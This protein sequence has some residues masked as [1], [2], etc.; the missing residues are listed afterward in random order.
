MVVKKIVLPEIGEGVM[1]AEIMKWY[2]KEGDHVKKFQNLVQVLADKGSLD[3]PSP[4]EGVVTKILVNE[5]ELVRVGTPI[6]EIETKDNREVMVQETTERTTEEKE[7][8]Q[9]AEKEIIEKSFKERPK[10][11]PAVRKLAAQLGISL[12]EIKGTGPGG[13]IT[14]DDVLEFKKR[15]EI[16]ESKPAEKAEILS[17]I[18][19]G[20]PKPKLK[21]KEER[22]K[23]KGIRRFIAERMLRAWLRIPHSS[24]TEIVIADRLIE[25]RERLKKHAETQGI[26]LT[27]MPFIMKAVVKALKEYPLLNGLYDPEWD[28]II[29]KKYYNIG[30]AVDTPQGLVVPVIKNVDE[31]SIFQLAKELRELAE[32]AREG[33]L[34]V[35]DVTDGTFSITNIG[36]IGS[37]VFSPIINYPEIAILGVSKIRKIYTEEGITNQMLVS[38]TF[39]HMVVDGAYAVRF[40]LKIK[41]LLEEPMLLL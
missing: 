36:S 18:P 11:S 16:E 4:Y 20:I 37:Y 26:K 13:I 28:E 29:I 7:T 12:E 5:G 8:S 40:L 39:N 17:W 38:I 19:D 10:A 9:K 41:E 32:K 25:A 15:M 34:S 24:G 30:F 31:K 1:E 27:Y 33:K 22:I 21:D 23:V 2:V 6:L 35:E 3:I 14:R